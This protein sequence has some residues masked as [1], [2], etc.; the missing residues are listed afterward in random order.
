MS[1][2]LAK[3]QMNHWENKIPIILNGK[4]FEDLYKYS[5]TQINLDFLLINNN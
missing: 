2:T 4:L 5:S 3:V 1:Q